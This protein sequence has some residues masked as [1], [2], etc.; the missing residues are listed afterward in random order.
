MKIYRRDY[1]LSWFFLPILILSACSYFEWQ[2]YWSTIQSRTVPFKATRYI[3][4]MPNN[5][6]WIRTDSDAWLIRYNPDSNKLI[7][8]TIETSVGRGIPHKL[9]VSRAGILWGLGIYYTHLLGAHPSTNYQEWVLS[10]Y[11]EGTDQFIQIHDVDG[12]LKSDYASDFTED[13]QGNLW[14]VMKKD[15]DGKPLIDRDPFTKEIRRI[16]FPPDQ[17]LIRYD[18]ATNKAV[19]VFSSTTI[20]NLA[21]TP[22]G[23]VWLTAWRDD[24]SLLTGRLLLYEPSTD[25][26]EEFPSPL[27]HGSINY[28]FDLYVDR[29]G[30]LWLDRY[31]CLEMTSTGE[32]KWHLLSSPP[33]VFEGDL[34]LPNHTVK[35]EVGPYKLYESSDGRMWFSTPLGLVMYDRKTDTWRRMSDQFHDIVED[36][37]HR[38]WSAADS[39]LYSRRLSW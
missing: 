19:Q 2:S 39:Q 17:T 8:Y 16:Y 24:R 11:D 7:T 34:V 14:I 33:E 18:P 36:K 32:R 29:S 12:I 3:V 6:I 26:F 37:R 10:R 1:L 5:D 25:I 13:P 31:A 20:Y 27:P 22:D 35:E 23:L 21:I 28:D 4:A 38:L 9:F 15:S 30:N